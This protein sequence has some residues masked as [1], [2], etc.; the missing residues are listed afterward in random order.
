MIL[1]RNVSANLHYI[2]YLS[3][4][5][6]HIQICQI[7]AVTIMTRQFHEFFESSI[8]WVF[9]NRPKLDAPEGELPKLDIWARLAAQDKLAE[10]VLCP[11][12]LG[13]AEQVRLRSK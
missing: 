9:D 3:L 11:P 2:H 1:T 13:S 10:S 6:L 5:R 7:V 4:P 8:W 12:K